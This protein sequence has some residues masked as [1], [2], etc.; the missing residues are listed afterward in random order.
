VLGTA[1]GG[2]RGAALSGLVNLDRG[3]VCGLELAG[4]VNVAEGMAGAQLSGLVD[5]AA[6]D[7]E[8]V[9]AGLVNVATGR[10]RGL[11][12]GLV[13]VAGDTNVQVGLVNV[14]SDADVQVGLVNVDLHGRL[15]LDA[16]TKPETGTVLAALKHGPAHVHWIYAFEMNVASGRPWAALGFGAHAT[17]AERLYVDVDLMQ[18]T[19]ILPTGT[20]PNQ[21]SEVRR[22]R[23]DTGRPRRSVFLGPTFNVLVAPSLSRADA[24]GYASVLGNASTSSVRAWPGAVIGLE[25]L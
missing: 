24:P 3:P 23:G 9:Q 11:Q 20:A 17:P 4:L 10:L 22:A 6:G 16:W 2:A 7:S 12:A 21:L 18:H 5:V 8:G 14:A 19:Q 13:S 15:R 1:S 25:A